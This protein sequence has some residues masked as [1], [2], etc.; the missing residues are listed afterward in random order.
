MGGC[1]PVLEGH[2]FLYGSDMAGEISFVQSNVG[3]RTAYTTQ[4]HGPP[5]VVV[6]PWVTHLRAGRAMSGYGEFNRVLV[7]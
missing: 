2:A 6:P 5:L 1:A 7:E 3:A 4:G